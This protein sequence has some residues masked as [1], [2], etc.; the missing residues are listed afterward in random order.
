MPCLPFYCSHCALFILRLT[1]GDPVEN[2]LGLKATA[3]EMQKINHQLGLDL[4]MHSQYL[5]YLGNLAKGDMGKTIVG[6]KDVSL[7]L[8]ERMAPTMIIAF[9]SVSLSAVMGIFLGIMAGFNKSR[10]FD[11]SSRLLSLLALAFPIFSLAP[12]LVFSF[13][14][15]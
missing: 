15:N 14:L 4:P 13:Q 12:L 8:K 5:Q 7:L 1:P 6:N 3:E 2:I 10:W 11:K 9:S